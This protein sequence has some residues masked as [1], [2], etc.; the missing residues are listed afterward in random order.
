M[1]NLIGIFRIGKDAEV[2]YT[3]QG[4]AVVNLSLAYNYGQKQGDGSRKTQWIEV[5]MWDKQAEALGP[6]LK[7]G[8]QIYA[9]VGDP[10]IEMYKSRDGG[11]GFKLVG[12]I[13]GIEFVSGPRAQEDRESD[14]RQSAQRP[15]NSTKQKPPSFDDLGDDIPF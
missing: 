5:S 11:E 2:R 15:A 10:H 4:K 13:S 9:V 8:G 7:K 14:N 12:N 1:A 3:P 6:Y